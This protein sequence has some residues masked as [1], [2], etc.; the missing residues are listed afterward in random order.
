MAGT[1]ELREAELLGEPLP[2]GRGHNAFVLERGQR[3]HD[4]GATA[5]DPPVAQL[6][7][8]PREPML[9]FVGVERAILALAAELSELLRHARRSDRLERASLLVSRHVFPL[10]RAMDG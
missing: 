6:A 9:V 3:C 7:D 5:V 8:H 1:T 10:S 2:I 4:V